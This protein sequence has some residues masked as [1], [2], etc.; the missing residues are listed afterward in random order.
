MASAQDLI[1]QYGSG[2]PAEYT[3]PFLTNFIT[4]S[5]DFDRQVALQKDTQEYNAQQAELERVFS[6]NEAL[7]NRQFQERMSN[8]AYQR[9]MQDIKAAGLNP[10]LLYGSSGASASTPTGATASGSA[11]SAGSGSVSS[12]RSNILEFA[13]GFAK[14]GVNT[15]LGVLDY[16]LAKNAKSVNRFVVRG[17]RD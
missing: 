14:L 15:A 6:A 9:A 13:L 5:A 10:A 7:K 2:A 3:I 1:N 4:G 16:R 17:F 8:T 11:A 12:P